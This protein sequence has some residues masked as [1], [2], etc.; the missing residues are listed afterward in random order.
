M[1]DVTW[2]ALTLTLT[3]LGGIWTWLAFRRRGVASGLRAAGFTLLP[4]AA[5]LTHTLQLFTE[6]LGAVGDWAT[7]LVFNPFTWLGI[8]LAG[9]S[10][11]LIGVSGF[12]SSRQLGQKAARKERRI[13]PG[14]PAAADRG[15]A[16]D[17]D[18][19]EIEA[20][21]RKRGIS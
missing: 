13:G 8:M 21:L 10:V 5:W 20:L 19:A 6:I 18:L 16:I 4:T 9:V 11:L 15:P 1:D 2:G 14:K 17:D 3:L 12:L 7:S